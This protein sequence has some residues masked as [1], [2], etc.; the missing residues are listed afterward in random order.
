MATTKDSRTR[1]VIPRTSAAIRDAIEDDIVA[2]K[3]PSGT[4]L[5]EAGLCARFNVSRTLVREALRFLGERGLVQ[6]IRNRGAFV[7]EISMARLIEMFEVMAGLEGM[8]GRLS[9]R[10]MTIEQHAVLRKCHQACRSALTKKNPDNY[11]YHNEAFHDAILAG[12][13]NS[14]L[15]QQVTALRR[16]LAPYRRMQLRVA[17]RIRESFDEHQQIVEAI[18]AAH[19]R[20]AEL[21]LRKH[22]FIQGERFTD[23]LASFNKCQPQGTSS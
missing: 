8:A 12:S 2:S 5:D 19:E 22:V 16:R 20:E 6:L 17:R 18:V 15:T 21:L 3:I 11:Y 4:K 7:A 13:N 10:R 9:A 23:F 1:R 14:F